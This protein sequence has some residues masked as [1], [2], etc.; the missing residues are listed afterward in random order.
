MTLSFYTSYFID[1]FLF[2]TLYVSVI[3]ILFFYFFPC[4]LSVN[5]DECRRWLRR[6]FSTKKGKV[7]R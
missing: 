3:E 2:V 7:Y 4:Y 1:L 5:T 6:K